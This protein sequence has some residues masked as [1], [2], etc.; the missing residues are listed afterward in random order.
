MLKLKHRCLKGKFNLFLGL[1]IVLFQGR[2]LGQKLNF[3][4]YSVERGLIQSQAHYLEQD[5][6]GLMWIATLGGIS[7]FDGKKFVNYSKRN[8]LR[9]QLVYRLLHQ[10]DRGLWVGHQNGLQLFDGRE[11]KLILLEKGIP[12]KPIIDIIPM[13]NHQVYALNSNGTLLFSINDSLK[14]AKE[15][16]D[17]KFFHLIKDSNGRSYGVTING[18]YDFSGEAHLYIRKNEIGEGIEIKQLYFNAQND[19]WIITNKGLYARTEQGFTLILSSDSIPSVMKSVVQDSQQR[20]WVGT[21]RG[22]YRIDQSGKI[23]YVGSRSGLTDN[24]VNK[25]LVDR[26]NNLW[27]ATDADGLFKLSTNSLEIIDDTNG[28]NGRV[29]MGMTKDENGNVWLGS[30]DGGLSSYSDGVIKK[31]SLPSKKTESKKVIALHFD[32]SATLWIGTLGSGLWTMKNNSF[33]QIR[34]WDGRLLDQVISI[35][36]D[37]E[38]TIWIGTPS[39]LFYYKGGVLYKIKG[40]EVPCFGM[41]GLSPDSLLVG[42]TVGLLE[43]IN[44][45][46]VA[47]KKFKDFTPGTV[48]CL[49]NSGDLILVGT[50]DDGV[51]IWDP[52]KDNYQLCSSVDGL[53]SDFIF[54]L[55]S[56]DEHTIFAG[57]GRGISRIEYEPDNKKIQVTNFSSLQNPFGPECNLNAIL[58]LENNE[59]WFG[60][61]K[62]IYIYNNKLSK[63][64]DQTPLIYLNAVDIYPKTNR[65]STIADTLLVW[66]SIPKDLKLSHRE[67]HITFDFTGVFYSNPDG[68]KYRYQL[69]GADDSLSEP[70][71]TSKIIYPNLNPGSYRFKAIALSPENIESSNAIDFTFTIER[72]Y[73]QKTWF[74]ILLVGFLIFLGFLFEFIRV[75]LK[76]KQLVINEKI[77]LDEQKKILERTS[78]DLHDDLGN[79]IT[80]ITVLTDVLQRK[81]SP[82]DIEKTKLIN[83]IRDNAEA[84]YVSTKDILWSLTPGR[85]NL[86]DTLEKSRITGAQLFEDTGIDF[87]ARGIENSLKPVQ[88][89]L[90]ISRNLNMIL[91]EAFTN[92]LRHSGASKAIMDI[93]YSN[94]RILNIEIRDNGIG[95][96]SMTQNGGNGLTNMHKRMDRIGGF[97]HTFNQE[98][99]GFTV[100]MH[101]KIPLNEG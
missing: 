45:S 70:S 79:K 78:E 98:T 69:V 59:I 81:V 61:T 18:V 36:E 95:L 12:V 71:S 8:G 49:A 64:V 37:K 27:F 94:D 41:L 42:T 25:M 34:T 13:N 26:E 100:K 9:S 6:F 48:N 76:Q 62:G 83:Q 14:I 93:K 11:F 38:H 30:I 29:V 23:D 47:V 19:L 87:E 80:R 50:E 51:L 31:I 35:Y 53:Q 91:K 46:E 77:R 86:F 20:I 28:L 58:K 72:P 44:K 4:N 32:Q 52:V 33:T 24:T 16:N 54:S 99:G 97:L 7:R 63:K 66:S 89:P 17:E 55:Y 57:T 40:I 68:L 73:Y 74:K 101:I 75:K 22:A 2:C 88:V 60:T 39:G 67:N 5:S 15:F 21:T 92:I 56:P 82:D 96:D 65:D 1:F 90:A 85:D 43:V 3:V 84:L 10:P